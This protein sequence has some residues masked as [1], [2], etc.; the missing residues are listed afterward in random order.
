MGQQ[1]LISDSFGLR[2]CVRIE[3][4]LHSITDIVTVSVAGKDLTVESKYG[5]PPSNTDWIV[6][7]ASGFPDEALAYK[8]GQT[9]QAVVQIAGIC[10]GPCVDIGWDTER[11]WVNPDY[12]RAIGRLHPHQRL[13]RDVHGLYV[14]PDDENT[15]FRP[16]KPATATVEADPTP[17]MS[18]IRQ[19]S[20]RPTL[21]ATFPA[22]AVRLL[23]LAR[24]NSE[25][26]ARILLSFAAI[27]S[28]VQREKWTT[29]ERSF[30]ESTASSVEDDDTILDRRSRKRIAMAVRRAHPSGVTQGVVSLLKSL[31]L[32]SKEGEWRALYSQRSRV[33]HGDRV[34]PEQAATRFAGDAVQF[35]TLVVLS[36]IRQCGIVLPS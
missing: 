26:S 24:M 13:G 10:S 25:P 29:A 15:I 6:F 30:L 16:L 7:A 23:N 33:I 22:R 18:A 28:L 8:Y 27:E 20:G 36:A 11:S 4:S 2:L 14:Y 9:L 32:E 19:L 31:N 5:G 34:L 3:K 21:P 1:Q 35:A 12:L 17:F